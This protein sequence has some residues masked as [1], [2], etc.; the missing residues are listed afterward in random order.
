MTTEV[1]G[2]QPPVT[3]VC[4]ICG[5]STAAVWFGVP[6]SGEHSEDDGSCISCGPDLGKRC[7]R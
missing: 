7:A 6:G 3:E 4:V 1:A 2:I 5:H